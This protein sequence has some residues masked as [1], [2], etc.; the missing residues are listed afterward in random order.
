M[1]LLKTSV[2]SVI[3]RLEQDGYVLRDPSVVRMMKQFSIDSLLPDVL[4]FH[5][6]ASLSDHPL[7]LDSHII[8][9]DKV[10]SCS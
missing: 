4:V 3:T 10:C 6:S 1:N 2:E 8:L 5:S 7:C 9:Q